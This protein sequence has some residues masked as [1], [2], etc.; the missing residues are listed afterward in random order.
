MIQHCMSYINK[1]Q[2]C[3][4]ATSDNQSGLTHTKTRESR[5][6]TFHAWPLPSKRSLPPAIQ[7]QWP[8]TSFQGRFAE[9][10]AFGYWLGRART[11][12]LPP[13]PLKFKRSV[14]EKRG[15]GL[16]GDNC[17]SRWISLRSRDCHMGQPTLIRNRKE[18]FFSMQYLILCVNPSKILK[19]LF[20]KLPFVCGQNCTYWL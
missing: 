11:H 15:G 10:L 9:S 13:R 18:N 5:S 3:A 17:G 12:R 1:G 7:R 14:Q 6:L 19:Y 4:F 8:Q 2:G 20:T 16:G